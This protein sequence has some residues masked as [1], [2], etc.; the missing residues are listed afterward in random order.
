MTR[1][2]S[3]RNVVGTLAQGTLV[4]AIALSARGARAQAATK[5]TKAQAQ[6]Q[7]KPSNGQ[8]CAACAF[9]VTPA[10]CQKVEGTVQ[11]GGWCKNFQQKK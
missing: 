11:P 2:L 1:N 5:E 3:R 4:T 9:F 10:S 8:M 7:D 6:Y